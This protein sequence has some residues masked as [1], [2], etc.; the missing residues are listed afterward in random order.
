MRKLT[1]EKT[2]PIKIILLDK[3]VSRTIQILN[4]NISYSMFTMVNGTDA[5]DI[6]A[7]VEQNTS[8]CKINMFLESIVNNCTAVDIDDLV[9][10]D[11][12]VK[13][14]DNPLM[15]MPALNETTLLAL[16]HSKMN[17][18]SGNNTHIEKLKLFD[19]DEG[20]AYTYDTSESEEMDYPELPETQI[21]WLGEFPYWDIAWWCRNDISIYDRGAKDSAEYDAWIEAKEKNNVD[22]E[23]KD[24]LLQIEKGI[25]EAFI[26]DV[27]EKKGEL[28]EID[29]VKK[30]AKNLDKD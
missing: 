26:D 1:L 6:E 28:V 17:A 3:D 19:L 23:N 30:T 5:S 25:R 20:V 29:F 15:G 10:L 14:F 8:Y 9:A 11:P 21:E 2:C 27:P 4:L 12:L 16:I 24:S 18:I 13:M 7:Q 22:A